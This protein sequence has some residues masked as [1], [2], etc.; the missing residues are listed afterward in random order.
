[1][2]EK[3]EVEI[4]GKSKYEAALQ[5]ARRILELEKKTDITRQEYLTTVYQCIT[6]LNGGWP[7]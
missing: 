2:T 4:G 6:V 7:F 5:M 3:V 1:M